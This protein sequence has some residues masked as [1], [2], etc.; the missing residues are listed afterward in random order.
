[1]RQASAWRVTWNSSAA[2]LEGCHPGLV[3]GHG[4]RPGEP[5]VLQVG[6]CAEA[7][8]VERRTGPVHHVML[9]PAET[10]PVSSGTHPRTFAACFISTVLCI[11][12]GT[13]VCE[14]E[15]SLQFPRA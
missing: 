9:A 5:A 15:E 7:K 4:T 8:G 14:A 1:M 12:L 3:G 10:A 11:G 6:G 13:V 2:P